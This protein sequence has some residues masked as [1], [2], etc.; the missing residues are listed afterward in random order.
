MTDRGCLGRGNRILKRSVTA[1]WRERIA[2]E[3]D[4]RA[5]LALEI[6]DVREVE[7]RDRKTER[8]RVARARSKQHGH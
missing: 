1:V 3:G 8:P 4:E 6:T 2:D 5:V 7:V